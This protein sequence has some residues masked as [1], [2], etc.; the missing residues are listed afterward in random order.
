MFE[1]GTLKPMKPYY[2]FLA[3]NE[4]YKLGSETKSESDDN[5][6]Y[7][8]SAK[9]DKKAVLISYY[10]GV[11]AEDKVIELHLSGF[12][13]PN[14]KITYKILNNEFNLETTKEEYIN[15]SA[16]TLYNKMEA[17][18]VMLLTIE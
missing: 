13:K 2:S 17:N 5:D 10:G 11:E 4:L 14:S 7:V 8:L 3:F 12:D 6:V 16:V 9:G 15:G 18:S 1:L